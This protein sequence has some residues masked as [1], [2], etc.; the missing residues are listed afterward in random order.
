MRRL[1]K[2]RKKSYT[3]WRESTY[4]V[5]AMSDNIVRPFGRKARALA[6]IDPDKCTGGR[7][8]RIAGGADF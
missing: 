5:F 6:L 1:A 7:V 8:L 3:D 4:E 2:R